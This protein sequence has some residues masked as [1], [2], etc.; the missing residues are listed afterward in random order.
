MMKPF[1]SIFSKIGKLISIFHLGLWVR[2]FSHMKE[3]ENMNINMVVGNWEY[4]ATQ[5]KSGY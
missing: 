5:N 1:T 3:R 4:Q 2:V